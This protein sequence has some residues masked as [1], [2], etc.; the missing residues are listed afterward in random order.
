M[1]VTGS[2]EWTDGEA[3]EEAL[4]GVAASTSPLGPFH[5]GH[6]TVVHGGARGADTLAHLAARRLGMQTE[7]HR[8]DWSVGARGGIERNIKMIRTKPDVCLAFILDKST[9]ATHCASAA[10]KAG[11]RTIRFERSST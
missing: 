1:L 4:V 2:R 6:V 10:E 7:V 5:T 3:I 8:P 9:G 11:I